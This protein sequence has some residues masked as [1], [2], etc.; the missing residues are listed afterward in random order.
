MR[1]V[2]YKVDILI[3]IPICGCLL[4][5]KTMKHVMVNEYVSID[6]FT[7]KASELENNLCTQTHDLNIQ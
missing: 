5:N 3:C 2:E 1:S 4:N 6:E 7:A